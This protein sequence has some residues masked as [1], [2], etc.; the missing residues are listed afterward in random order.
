[1][2]FDPTLAATRFGIGLSPVIETPWDTTEMIERLAGPDTVAQR[3]PIAGFDATSPSVLHL[4]QANAKRR[5]AV[6]AA[7]QEAAQ[8]AVRQNGQDQVAVQR[9][10]MLTTLA[11]AVV[12]PDGLRERL[13]AFWADHFT[14]IARGFPYRHMVT[15]FVADAIR[16]HVAGR[17]ADMVKAVVSHPMMLLYLEQTRSLGPRSPVGQANGGGLNENLGRELLELHLVGAQGGYDQT[18]VTEMAELLTGLSYAPT[19]GVTYKANRAEPGS[20]VVM[21]RRYGAEASLA[22][23]E[24][25]LDDLARRPETAAHIAHKLAVHFVSD[26]PDTD[27]VA[28][29]TGSFLDT[30]GDLLAVTGTLLDHPAAWV[31][32]RSKVRQ[33]FVFVAAALRALGVRA[34]RIT[35]LSQRDYTR[36]IAGPLTLMGQ[37]WEKPIGPDGWAESAAAWI[38]PQALAGRITWAMTSPATFVDMLP[39]PR[40]FVATAVGPQAPAELSFAAAAAESLSDGVGLVLTA[41]AFQRI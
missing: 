1:M 14:V 24:A 18:D 9:R 30:G 5:E 22:T 21:G 8:E 12:S 16:P 23:V 34:D 11:R 36:H 7:A 4:V 41:P 17:F 38:T 37:P 6:G 28:A 40:A 26:T 15:P 13:T 35:S 2:T 32:Q 19:V 25:A 31:P 33:P 27:L 20:E 10:N 39:D 29:L 3:L